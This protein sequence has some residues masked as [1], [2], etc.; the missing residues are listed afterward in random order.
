MQC[1]ALFGW[2]GIWVVLALAG[3]VQDCVRRFGL[4][5][6]QLDCFSGR[7]YHQLDL[8][9]LG[10]PPHL[11]YDWQ[12]PMCSGSDDELV[13]LPR[14]SFFHRKRRMAKVVPKLLG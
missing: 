3:D 4:A 13:T 10:F 2:I 6:Q 9:S 5:F 8:A 12:V 1:A 11:I 14:D 7:Q